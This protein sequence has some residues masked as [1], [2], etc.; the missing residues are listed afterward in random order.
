MDIAQ[1]GGNS[2]ENVVSKGSEN[3][4]LRWL[5]FIS[6]YLSIGSINILKNIL[7]HRLHGTHAVGHMGHN[8]QI[9]DKKSIIILVQLIY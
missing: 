9:Q 2:S 1:R 8:W 6:L 7:G 4:V 5:V 3:F